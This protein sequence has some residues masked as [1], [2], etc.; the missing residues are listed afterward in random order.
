M[1]KCGDGRREI[2]VAKRKLLGIGGKK[3]ETA[4]QQRRCSFNSDFQ[5]GNLSFDV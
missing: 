4:A 1:F 3:E 5:V 2:K